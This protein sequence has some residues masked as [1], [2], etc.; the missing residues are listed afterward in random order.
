MISRSDF[1]GVFWYLILVL[2]AAISSFIHSLVHSFDSNSTALIAM[3]QT[4][5]TT[6][7]AAGA[8]TTTTAAPAASTTGNVTNGTLANAA[9]DANEA[10]DAAKEVPTMKQLYEQSTQYN[11]WRYTQAALDEMRNKVNT[12]AA[13]NIKANID[14]ERGLVWREIRAWVLNSCDNTRHA[15]VADL[16]TDF[17]L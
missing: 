8:N 1:G 16:S 14:E 11:H 17:F 15:T 2:S 9:A 7:A 12:E 10:V 13:A 6:A 4:A 5:A 3:T